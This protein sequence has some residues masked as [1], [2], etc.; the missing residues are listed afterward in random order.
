MNTLKITV[1]IK[2]S[3]TKKLR[4]MVKRRREEGKI[5]S[6]QEI[7]QELLVAPTIDAKEEIRR[8]I[9]F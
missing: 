4:R 6:Q 5:T 8:S 2:K 1:F 9:E 7:I 3:F